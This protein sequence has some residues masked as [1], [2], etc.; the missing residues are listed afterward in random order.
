MSIT[1]LSPFCN[2][3][4]ELSFTPSYPMIKSSTEIPILGELTEISTTSDNLKGTVA[5]AL[6]D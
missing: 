5:Q 1:S 3:I 4:A 6:F 2:T